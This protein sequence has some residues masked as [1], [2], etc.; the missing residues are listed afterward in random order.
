MDDLVEVK[1][2]HASS[3]AHGPV[4][5]QGWLD[6]PACPKHLIQLS[7]G[8]VLHDDAVTWSLGTNTPDRANREV[9]T[10]C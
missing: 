5:E 9:R 3:D 4:H 8:T 7:L 10:A 6:L 1:V 2:V